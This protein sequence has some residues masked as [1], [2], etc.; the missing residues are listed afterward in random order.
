MNA[1][2]ARLK[3]CWGEKV[4]VS[5]CAFPPFSFSPFLPCGPACNPTFQTK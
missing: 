5:K 2:P 4:K 3:G 1:L